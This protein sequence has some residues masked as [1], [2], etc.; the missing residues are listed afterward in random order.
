[1]DVGLQ[2]LTAEIKWLLIQVRVYLNADFLSVPN[3]IVTSE[4]IS[5]FFLLDNE[6][7]PSDGS[8]MLGSCCDHIRFI[9]TGSS[10]SNIHDQVSLSFLI[11]NED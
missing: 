3:N 10:I 6:Y 9:E 2:R 11:G 4:D 8:W 5:L 1:M 7:R